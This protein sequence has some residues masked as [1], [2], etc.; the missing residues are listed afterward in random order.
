M[1]AYD[2]YG[3][4][5]EY[6]EH[7]DIVVCNYCKKKYRQETIEQIPGFRE[8]EED[9]CLYCHKSNGRSGSVEFW[10]SPLSDKVAK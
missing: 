6:A 2:E 1:L 9:I 8:V 4:L 10:N 7:E 5:R 3:N